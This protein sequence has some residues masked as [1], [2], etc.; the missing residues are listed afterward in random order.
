MSLIVE[1]PPEVERA[2]RVHAAARGKDVAV[3]VRE[4]IEEKLHT[5]PT[6]AEV[7]APIHQEVK[8]SGA[9]ETELDELVRASIEESRWSRRTGVC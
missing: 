9:S 5:L 6:F 4:F 2:L 7:L 3:L 8:E 1:L